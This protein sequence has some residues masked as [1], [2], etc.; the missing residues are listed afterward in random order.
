MLTGED[1]IPLLSQKRLAK[2]GEKE[3]KMQRR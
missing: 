2:C 1:S 3:G